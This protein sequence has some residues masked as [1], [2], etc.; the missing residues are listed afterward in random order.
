MTVLR[1]AGYSRDS[2]LA[3]RSTPESTQETWLRI[4]FADDGPGIPPGL[5]GRIFDPFFTTKKQGKGTGLGLSVCHGILR[6]HEGHI[7]AES[8]PGAGATFIAELPV[9]TA[10][11]T[12]TVPAETAKAPQ[13]PPGRVLVIDDEEAN[14]HLMRELLARH[15]QAVDTVPDATAA[16]DKIANNEYDAILCD[17]RMPGMSGDDLY[18]E[19]KKRWPEVAEHWIFLTGD[20]ASTRTRGFL[21]EV[22]RPVVE[23]PFEMAGLIRAIRRVH[24]LAEE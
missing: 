14:L 4:E 1:P 24:R 16:L 23:K 3:A 11:G 5:L 19:V 21:E 9:R 7:W 13:L 17:L 20:L 12:G 22:G 8:V 15:G 10:C 18:A 6:D 2:S